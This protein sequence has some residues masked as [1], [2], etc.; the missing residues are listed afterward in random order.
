L[1][2]I[3]TYT[4]PIDAPLQ[5]E[6]APVLARLPFR[7]TRILSWVS[8]VVILTVSI[9]L[10]VFIG[11]TASDT[12]L[13]RQQDYNLLVGINLSQQVIRRFVLP[14]ARITGGKINLIDPVQFARIDEI[15]RESIRGLDID[16]LRIFGTDKVVNYSLDT[17]ELGQADKIR[18]IIEH[19]MKS[20]TPLF[21]R[22][23]TIPW[24]KAIF[25]PHPPAK[26]FTLHMSFPLA[27]ITPSSS[28]E[29][30][31]Q[32]FGA[33]EIIQDVSGDYSS[34]IRLQW[35][36][37]S[38]CIGTSTFMFCLL[39]FALQKA[40]HALTERIKRNRRLE[41]RVH[42]NERLASMGRVIASIAHEVRNPLGII[43]S[44]AELLLRRK[45]AIDDTDK[46]ILTAVYDESCRLSQT[47]N[48]FLD[49]ARP[50]AIRREIFDLN[51]IIDQA[52][53]F[54]EHELDKNGVKFSRNLPRP[55][56]ITGDKDLL[57][58]ALYNIFSNSL[59]AM[60]DGGS[61]S[62]SGSILEH[63]VQIEIVDSG[64]GFPKNGAEHLVE[65]FYTTKDHGTGLGLAIVNTIIAGHTGTL[66]LSNAPE[67]G[68]KTIITL[69]VNHEEEK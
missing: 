61:L 27:I 25:T 33:M 2:N 15:I 36:I 66:K 32:I 28:G 44:S 41:A 65:P 59:Q 42:E 68:A 53:G 64:P 12:L 1:N 57:Y 35:I 31:P 67:G 29:L 21:E 63:T 10:A 56:F 3:E 34:V 24:F 26:T 37:L 51:L 13:S 69:P 39:K 58:R 48:D 47:V 16:G 43:R 38:L 9:L 60:P 6:E 23:S 8:L 55:F 45:N 22:E 4:N 54:L 7:L 50:R 18:P 52:A 11:N 40:E 46:R 62:I 30:K 5:L 20:G 19:S 49:Y 17:K 14:T